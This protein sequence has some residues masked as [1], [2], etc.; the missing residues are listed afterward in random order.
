MKPG[1]NRAFDF[2]DINFIRRVLQNQN[3]RLILQPQ[4]MN[5]LN[6]IHHHHATAHAGRL[7]YD[8]I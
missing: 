8:V 6:H 5:T 2:N 3:S 4:T 7:C 1:I